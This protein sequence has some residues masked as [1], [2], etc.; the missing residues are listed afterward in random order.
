MRSIRIFLTA[1][2]L[3][4]LIL[5]NFIAA[6]QGF[7]FSMDEAETLFD[8]QLLD[9]SKLVSNLDFGRGISD[10]RLG[11]N[12]AFQ[13]WDKDV[14]LAQS[15]NAPATPISM[16]A[17]GFD[18]ANFNSYRWR[19]FTSQ[20]QASLRWTIVAERTDLRFELAENV[21]LKSVVPILI[22]IPLIGVLIWSIISYG[23]RP[24]RVLSIELRNKQASDLSPVEPG[25][26][27]DE[28]NQVVDSIN[29]FIQR[30]SSVLEREKRFF[31]RCGP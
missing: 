23:L 4:T 12:L 29:G 15:H 14:L 16:F 22:S 1:G 9:A 24:L 28:L 26:S 19:T 5:F 17:A 25:N 21:V 7:R 27:V 30:L 11:N 31:S 20:E 8:N 3:A 2:I 6:L 18:F 13:V 10:L